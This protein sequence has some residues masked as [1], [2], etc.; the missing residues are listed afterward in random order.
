MRWVLAP[1]GAPGD[2]LVVDPYSGS[3][4][5]GVAA[6]ESGRSFIGV[7]LSTAYLDIAARRLA[8]AEND[9][10]PLS[11]FAPSTLSTEAAK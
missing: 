7:E 9:G 2:G 3:G 11:L 4:S 8:Q 5:T 6:V 1:V 10:V